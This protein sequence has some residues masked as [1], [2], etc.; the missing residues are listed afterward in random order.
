MLM[1]KIIQLIDRNPDKFKNWGSKINCV[2]SYCF[3]KSNDSVTRYVCYK[4]NT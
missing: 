4:S 3:V 2:K 1:T